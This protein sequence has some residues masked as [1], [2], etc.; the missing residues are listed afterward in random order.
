MTR[1]E[2][3]EAIDRGGAPGPARAERDAGIDGDAT[4]KAGKPSPRDGDRG[5]TSSADDCAAIDL[6]SVQDRAS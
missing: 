4:Q 1:N 3:G 6:D 5:G 2:G